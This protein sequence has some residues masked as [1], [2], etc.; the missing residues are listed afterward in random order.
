[1]NTSDSILS[2]LIEQVACYRRL[3]KLAE[4]Q[5]QFV[6]QSQTEQL[7]GVLT[8]RQE[9]LDRITALEKI[10]EPARKSW[11]AYCNGLGLDGRTTAEKLVVE[12]KKLLEEIMLADRNDTI[13]LQQRKIEINRQMAQAGRGQ[14][15]NRRYAASA[16]G[17]PRKSSVDVRSS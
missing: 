1:M 5:H 3:A 4:Q 17:M 2:A 11:A 7:L 10:I 6:Q 13:V 14:Q 8:R 15:A 12:T 9:V 16:Y